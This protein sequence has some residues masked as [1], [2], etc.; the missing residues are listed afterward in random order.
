MSYLFLV[1][2]IITGREQEEGK[3]T[4]FSE[5]PLHVIFCK[6]HLILPLEPHA[7]AGTRSA[8]QS[9]GTASSESSHSPKW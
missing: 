6:P 9:E 8:S 5:A 3:K 1:S 7:E 4:A 2:D